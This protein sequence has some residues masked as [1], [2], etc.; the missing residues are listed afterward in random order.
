LIMVVK[1][2]GA[3]PSS[4]TRRAALVLI[5]KRVPFEFVRVHLAQ[6][7]HKKPEYVG[8][9]HPFG[10]V[11]A[12]EDEDG[13]IVYESRAIG[14]YIAQKYAGQG[15]PLLPDPADLK[16][17]ATYEVGV[18]VEAFQFDPF[19]YPAARELVYF[20]A[21]GFAYNTEAGKAALEALKV[22]LK[23]YDAI[24]GKQKYLAGDQLSIVDLFHLPHATALAE[25]V[26]ADCFTSDETPNVKRWWNEISNL[27]SWLT[28]K[29][30]IP[31][32][33]TA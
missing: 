24:L 17:V 30:G 21:R 20:P 28:L 15:T 6:G 9:Y 8:K 11:P 22:K 27:P 32:R 29:N 2:Y 14:R 33:Y 31:E 10:Q 4:A 5:E 19:A 7:E 16:A 13:T 1:L 3:D 25:I 18:S 12:L 23:G 26:K